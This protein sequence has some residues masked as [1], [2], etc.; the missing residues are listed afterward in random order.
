MYADRP[1]AKD[2][3]AAVGDDGINGGLI[4]GPVGRAAGSQGCDGHSVRSTATD[5]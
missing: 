4:Y 1:V 3:L 2:D 5:L